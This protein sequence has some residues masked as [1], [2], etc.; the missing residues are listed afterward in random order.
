MAQRSIPLTPGG[1]ARLEN[2]LS[3]LRDLATELAIRIHEESESGDV[4]DNSEYEELKDRIAITAG[5]IEELEQT[6]A[7]AVDMEPATADGTVRLGSTVTLVDGDGIEETWLLVTHAEADSMN[8]S[9]STDS[10]VGRALMGC[11]VGD[12]VSTQTP[13]GSLRMTVT[14]VV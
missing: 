2:E 3:S 14:G 10:P 12:I 5:K 4:S 13:T 6:L 11:H 1:R 8:G 9:I 7:H